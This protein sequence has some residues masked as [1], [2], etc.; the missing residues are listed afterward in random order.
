MTPT[1]TTPQ[2]TTTTQAQAPGAGAPLPP[3]NDATVWAHVNVS[4]GQITGSSICTKSVCGLNGEW[5]GYLPPPTYA[6]GSVWWPT[7]TRLI[8]QLPGSAGYGSGTFNFQ[9]YV[10]TV[11]GGTIYNGIFTPTASPPV[12]SPPQTVTTTSTTTV[13]VSL[14]QKTATTTQKAETQ[15]FYTCLNGVTVAKA[16]QCLT[17]FPQQTESAPTAPLRQ[18]EL[19]R[20]P[21]ITFPTTEPSF[22]PTSTQMM[23]LDRLPRVLKIIDGK[24]R[25]ARTLIKEAQTTT[26]RLKI[27]VTE[28]LEAIQTTYDGMSAAYTTMRNGSFDGDDLFTY[29]NDQILKPFAVIQQDAGAIKSLAS[30]PKYIKT[31]TADHKRYAARLKKLQREDEYELAD[32]AESVLTQLKEA[33]DD[34]RVLARTRITTTSA[35]DILAV[36]QEIAYLRLSADELL[37]FLTID[38]VEERVRSV[39]LFTDFPL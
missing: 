19:T 24:M 26:K 36:M 34:L 18:P 23:Q 5:H 13:P 14:T 38:P 32:D 28:Q 35:P 39:L 6:S 27:N 30:L 17:F 21:L 10:F 3:N 8:W 9:T 33:A 16:E 25:A 37:G 2:T 31:V 15:F 20:G 29:V 7:S 22:T 4:T 1:S 11:S 12:T